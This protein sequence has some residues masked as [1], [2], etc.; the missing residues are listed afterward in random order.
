MKL[1]VKQ[2]KEPGKNTLTHSVRCCFVPHLPPNFHRID[3]HQHHCSLPLWLP[4]WPNQTGKECCGACILLCWAV[5][6]PDDIVSLNIRLIVRCA[7]ISL[8]F[9]LSK[10][11]FQVSQ[12]LVS[13]MLL[14]AL[15]SLH[16]TGWW[17]VLRL[18]R[19]FDTWGLPPGRP[20]ADTAG[21]KGDF[22]YNLSAAA[23]LCSKSER[24]AFTI[25]SVSKISPTSPICS[26]SVWD[27]FCVAHTFWL[28]CHISNK[29]WT[30][31]IW[32]KILSSDYLFISESFSVVWVSNT[33]QKPNL[34]LLGGPNPAPY[35][36]TRGFR[37][38][39]LDPLG[40]ISS[41]AFWVGLSMAAFRYPTVNRRRLSMVR[42]RSFWM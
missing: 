34:L 42:R 11:P 18:W 35:L 17:L 12:V 21:G 32:W 20:F 36:S 3:H 4:C 19:T 1:S 27:S 6:I 13:E 7:I 39:W 2:H 14:G 38:V 29:W 37:W 9:R 24:D 41:F 22:S 23:P 15:S 33:V 5:W 10:S 28:P 16:A 31:A 30:M 8:S 26:S 25:T 40:P